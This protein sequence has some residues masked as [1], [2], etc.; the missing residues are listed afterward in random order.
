MIGQKLLSLAGVPPEK[1]SDCMTWAFGEYHEEDPLEAL[2]Q[3]WNAKHADIFM[4]TQKDNPKAFIWS[5]GKA[6]V[7]KCLNRKI[8]VPRA[9]VGGPN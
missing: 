4:V 5:V 9:F 8:I 3:R 7:L 2:R 6:Y 1:L